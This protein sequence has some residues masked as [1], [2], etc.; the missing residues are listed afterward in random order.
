MSLN[1]EAPVANTDYVLGSIDY[2]IFFAVTRRDQ[3]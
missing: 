1:R 3:P 2:L